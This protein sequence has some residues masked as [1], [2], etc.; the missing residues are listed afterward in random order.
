LA[1]TRAAEAAQASK[2]AELELVVSA[3][4]Q[5]IAELQ[6]ACA[7]LRQEKENITASYWRLSD[8]HKVFVVK[9]EQ[10]KA[11]LVEA[12][13]VELAGMKEELDKE[14]QGYMDYRLNVRLRHSGKLRRDACPSPP[15]VQKLK[16]W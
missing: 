10:E 1:T 2:N 15:G 8:K 16:S 6:V 9:A 13:P 11:E 14:T 12:H 7:S 4:A 5:K 3:H